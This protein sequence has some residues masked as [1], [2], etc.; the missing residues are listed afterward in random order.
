MRILLVLG[1]VCAC[2]CGRSDITEGRYQGMVELD[3]TDLGFEVPGRVVRL[4][5]AVGSPVKAGQVV[6]RL[7][8][9]LDRATRDVRVAQ[10]E[11][12]RAE[13]ALV[14]AGSRSEDIRAARA[15]ARAAREAERI[16]EREA[17]RERILVERNASTQAQLDERTAQLARTRGDSD[18][19][20]ASLL[21]LARGARDEEIQ[22]ARA[23]VTEAEKAVEL[24]DET[25][26]KRVLA[27][28]ID[29]IANDVPVEVGEIVSSGTPVVSVV[30]PAHPYADVFVPVAELPRMRVGGPVTVVVEGIDFE[31]P[32]SIERVFS[33]LA[34]TPRF[35]FSPRERP[36]LMGRVRVRIDDRAGGLHAGMPAYAKRVTDT[37]EATRE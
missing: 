9:T 16:A 18:A 3:Q 12:A 8:D 28:P 33:E 34:Y 5:V 31:Y 1:L 15:K 32:A 19:A 7:D 6:A 29:G 36:N 23:R 35:V 27:S 10:L 22:R 4:E 24:A 13:L 14:L 2:A 21:E 30:A 11:T 37:R 25:I 17:E 26:A 20:D